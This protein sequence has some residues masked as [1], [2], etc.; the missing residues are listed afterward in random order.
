[1]ATHGHEPSIS[2]I[3]GVIVLLL[4]SPKHNATFKSIYK[5]AE[6]VS[7]LSLYRT[8]YLTSNIASCFVG[9]E[10]IPFAG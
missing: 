3:C 7:V 5:R 10:K 6:T 1:V 2:K 9:N 4:L 8:N